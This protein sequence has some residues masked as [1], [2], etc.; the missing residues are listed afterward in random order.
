MLTQAIEIG[1]TSA[2]R[3]VGDG[4]YDA[5]IETWRPDIAGA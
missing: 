4:E 1:Y 2:L 3:D 5:E